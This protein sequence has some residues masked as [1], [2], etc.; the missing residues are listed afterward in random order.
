MLLLDEA[1][2]VPFDFAQDRLVVGSAAGELNALDGPLLEAEQV[3][4]EELA[5]VVGVDSQH[6]EGEAGQD[7]AEAIFLTR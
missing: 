3:V 4:V 7:A 2:V 6:G 5:A 1:V